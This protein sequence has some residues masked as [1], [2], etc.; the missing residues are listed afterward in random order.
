MH[1][2]VITCFGTRDKSNTEHYDGAVTWKCAAPLLL[3]RFND[4]EQIHT[5][6]EEEGF[7]IEKEYGD[8]AG[9]IIVDYKATVKIMDIF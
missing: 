6:L 5:W 3:V 1:K 4:M 8:Y 7:Q 2:T 9:N